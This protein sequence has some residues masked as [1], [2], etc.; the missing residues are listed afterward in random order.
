MKVSRRNILL[1]GA[2]FGAGVLPS[3]PSFAQSAKTPKVGGILNAIAVG[4][5]TTLVPLLDS[6]T[7]TRVISTKILEG[8]VKFDEKFNPRPVLATAWSIS[9]DGLRYTFNLRQGV[10][11]HDG[12]DFSS[13][14]VRFSLLA[15]KRVGPRF[16][17]RMENG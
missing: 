16:M 7:R 4:E 3:L 14:D 1:L 5:P 15:F 12:K 17:W 10:K 6:N 13:A 11:W 8:L 2:A 9:Q